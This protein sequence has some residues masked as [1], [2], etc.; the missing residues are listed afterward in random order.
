MVSVMALLLSCGGC[1]HTAAGL[2]MSGDRIA[3]IRDGVTTRAEV[4]ETLGL[5]LYELQS[6]RVIAY[7]WETEGNVG[8]GYTVF[9]GY[10]EVSRKHDRFLFCVH[11]DDRG[12]V[13]QHGEVRQ[14]GTESSNDAIGRWLSKKS[15]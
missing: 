12:L 13:N 6:E 2:K 8:F 15:D 9:G 14:L 11:F 1:S 5:P 3:F 4:V 10:K 7:A